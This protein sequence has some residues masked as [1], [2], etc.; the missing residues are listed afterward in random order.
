[1]ND[2]LAR[3][4]KQC[5]N[6]D[7]AALQRLLDKCR[8]NEET[9]CLE[10]M[11]GMGGY[12]Q[13]TPV[14]HF[15][16]TRNCRR[17]MQAYKALWIMCGKAVPSGYSVY[18][19]CPNMRC[20]N[21][22]HCKLGTHAHMGAYIAKSGRYKGDQARILAAR[23]NSARQRTPESVVRQIEERLA[24]GVR[25]VDIA[26]ELGVSVST[27]TAVKQ[28]RHFHC[29]SRPKVIRGASVFAL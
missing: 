22:E 3:I 29:S 27:V 1:M 20:V 16:G 6:A 12:H 11:A 23:A 8:V 2:L 25:G 18:R 5:V 10:W 26:A 9:G 14:F 4:Y 21:P 15:P 28:K 19:T 17:S 7:Q 24:D 13:S